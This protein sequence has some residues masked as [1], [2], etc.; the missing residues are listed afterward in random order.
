MQHPAVTGVV[1]SSHTPGH[2]VES[3]LTRV[4]NPNHVM[5][6][7]IVVRYTIDDAF[8]AQ[9]G[10]ELVAGRAFS[11]DH[12][13]DGLEAMILNETAVQYFGYASPEEVLGKPFWQLGKNG[14]I[15]GVVKDFHMASL[16]EAITPLSL[17]LF[18]GDNFYST[19]RYFSLQI[20]TNNVRQTVAD[21]KDRWESLAPERPFDYSF[22]DATFDAQYRAE[23]RFGR[24][25]G[26]AAGLA[27]AIACL[28][29]LGLASYTM[30]QRTKEVGIRKVLGA[31]VS[32]I[33]LLFSKDFLKLVVIAYVVAVPVIYLVMSQWLEHFAYRIE[34]GAMIFV[35]TLVAVLVIA[36]L[37]VSYQAFRA[38]RANPVQS[39]KYE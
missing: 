24:L 2:G 39:L 32:S 16:G 10:L 18:A 35:I 27:I 31:S 19:F 15:I 21:L 3:W 29:L 30:Q 11:P 34:I 38:A 25:F 9:Y 33:V 4:E 14:R 28:G 23:E 26:I 7:G 13:T 1:V 37:S 6:D 8:M 22:L 5:Q 17:R 36:W 12:P 20:K